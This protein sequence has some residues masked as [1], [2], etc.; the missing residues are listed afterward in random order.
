MGTMISRVAAFALLFGASLHAG[1]LTG[2][3][4]AP[5]VD[6]SLQAKPETPLIPLNYRQVGEAPESLMWLLAQDGG[7]PPRCGNGEIEE[8]EICEIGELGPSCEAL[9]LGDNTEP[10]P[11]DST[12]SGWDTL[13]C[14]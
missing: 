2:A 11:C 14:E 10:L 5:D 13:Q 7:P 3:P 4:V 9:G 1:T 8:G 6:L 12:C